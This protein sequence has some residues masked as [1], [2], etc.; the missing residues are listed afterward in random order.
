[1]KIEDVLKL[2]D[3]G[4]SKADILALASGQVQTIETQPIEQEQTQEQAVP[5][6]APEQQT[7]EPQQTQNAE[8]SADIAVIKQ[9]LSALQKSNIIAASQPAGANKKETVDDV[10]KN[11]FEGGDT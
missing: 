2:V 11:F 5:E 10:W 1:M 4:F 9:Q 6:S 8:L 7:Q 3:A